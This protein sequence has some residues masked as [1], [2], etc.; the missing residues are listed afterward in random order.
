M[1]TERCTILSPRRTQDSNPLLKHLISL[2]PEQN[3]QAACKSS[4]G[5]MLKTAYRVEYG[6][7][8]QPLEWKLI[9]RSETPQPGGILVRWNPAGE[10]DGTY[11]IRLVVE[12]KK[13]GELSTFVVVTVGAA[14]TATATATATPAVVPSP[15]PIASL[16]GF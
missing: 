1:Q 12:D 11:T 9:V 16:N 10:P 14:T 4:S 15:T 2:G 3:L 8:N 7:G 5:Q 6:A 13:R